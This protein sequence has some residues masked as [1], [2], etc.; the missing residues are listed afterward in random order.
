M[1]NYDARK[2]SIICL[3]RASIWMAMVKHHKKKH[4]EVEFPHPLH[5]RNQWN[6]TFTCDARAVGDIYIWEKGQ[7]TIIQAWEPSATKHAFM[8]NC[9]KFLYLHSF[10][11]L[12]GQTYKN[13]N[14]KKDKTQYSLEILR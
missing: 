8:Q 6:R 1:N 3:R 11:E 7:F 14:Q 5:A 10:I 12:P 2:T 9:S 4:G 13:E